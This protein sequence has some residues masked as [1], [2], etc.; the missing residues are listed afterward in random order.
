MGPALP[1]LVAGP[2][3]TIF[4]TRWAG[5]QKRRRWRRG[6]SGS[7]DE[8]SD[9]EGSGGSSSGSSSGSEESEES[10][11]EDDVDEETENVCDGTLASPGNDGMARGRD[12]GVGVGGLRFELGGPMAA[13]HQPEVA[14]HT[15][16][17]MVTTLQ[18][19]TYSFLH[20]AI[21]GFLFETKSISNIQFCKVTLKHAVV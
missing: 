8:G 16:T 15:A 14:L 9:A 11:E 18:H 2:A 21:T 4:P 6:G 12:W 19:V 17:P 7:D 13:W 1:R 20:Q 10:E 5:R 3:Y